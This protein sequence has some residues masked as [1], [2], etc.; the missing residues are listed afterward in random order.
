MK[1][2]FALIIGSLFTLTGAGLLC[3]ACLALRHERRATDARAATTGVVVRLEETVGAQG[4]GRGYA[5]VVRFTSDR[6]Q[7]IEFISAVSTNPA[8]YKVGDK[9]AVRYDPRQP[10]NAEVDTFASRWFAF[11]A[12]V[13]LGTVFAASGLRLLVPRKSRAARASGRAAAPLDSSA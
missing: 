9:V 6:G 10:G 2:A 1:F 3:G 4:E 8:A 7:Q 11:A 5:P 12:L 13:V